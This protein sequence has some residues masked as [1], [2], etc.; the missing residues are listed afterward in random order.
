[1]VSLSN[2]ERDRLFISLLEVAA[3]GLLT[4]RAGTLGPRDCYQERRALDRPHGL[5]QILS[6]YREIAG[7]ELSL[8]PVA[9]HTDAALE[10]LQ[11]GATSRRLWLQR[12]TS[13]QHDQRHA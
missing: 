7:H 6:H 12:H 10:D 1:M 8:L 5:A 4:P 11:A 3:A 2:P 13:I 9:L